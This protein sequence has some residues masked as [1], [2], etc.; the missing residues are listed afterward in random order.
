MTACSAS[1][2]CLCPTWRVVKL[3]SHDCLE[4]QKGFVSICAS[5]WG[6]HNPRLDHI[7][8]ASPGDRVRVP[9]K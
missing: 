7:E 5:G 1:G 4:C 9:K 3:S 2:S 6:N 8:V